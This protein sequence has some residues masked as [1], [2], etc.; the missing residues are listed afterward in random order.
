[1]EE[2]KPKA[3]QTKPQKPNAAGSTTAKAKPAKKV[4][5]AQA[6]KNGSDAA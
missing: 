6:P 4:A 5:R 3:A 2:A 1:M